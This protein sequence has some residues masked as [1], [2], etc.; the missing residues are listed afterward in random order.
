MRM[1]KTPPA[2]NNKNSPSEHASIAGAGGWST[3]WRAL[4]Q[5]TCTYFTVLSLAVML[6]TLIIRAVDRT[7]AAAVLS[8]PRF[9]GLL[10]FAVCAAGAGLIRRSSLS[11]G[12]RLLLHATVSLGGALLFVYLPLARLQQ[13]RSAQ[14]LL[15]LLLFT[16]LYVAGLVIYLALTSRRRRTQNQTQPYSSQFRKP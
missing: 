16:L 15:W 3:V 9:L 11:G 7:A 5:H 2:T 8:V 10:G 1:N 13:H 14:V 6:I 12:I 4:W